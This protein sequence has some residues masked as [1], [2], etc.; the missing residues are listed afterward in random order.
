LNEGRKDDHQKA[1]W[2]LLPWGAVQ[3]VVEVL[4]HG[5]REYDADNWRFV[6]GPRR[7]Y[8]AAACRHLVAWRRGEKLD[9][10]S[11]LP[12]LAHAACDILFLLELEVGLGP[13]SAEMDGAVAPLPSRE[14]YAEVSEICAILR[15]TLT[16][17]RL[18]Q[19]ERLKEGCWP[20]VEGICDWIEQTMKGQR[21]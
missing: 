15:R 12:H 20:E 4:E 17:N 7:R 9:P 3:A 14:R 11:G 18:S 21:Q 6:K 13:T 16:G 10:K 1:P 5:R 2:D 19:E 8:F